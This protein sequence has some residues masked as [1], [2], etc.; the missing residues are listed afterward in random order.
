MDGWRGGA[1]TGSG[2]QE[3]LPVQGGVLSPAE[4]AVLLKEQ[5]W[6][7]GPR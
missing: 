5:S 6:G 7:Q 3:R 1:L 2:G 4:G